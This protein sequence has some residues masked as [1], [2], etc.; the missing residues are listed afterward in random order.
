[1]KVDEIL[2]A[3]TTIE[4]N[5]K[6]MTF[7]QGFPEDTRLVMLAIDSMRSYTK[8]NDAEGFTRYVQAGLAASCGDMISELVN[9]LWE[10]L[11]LDDHTMWEE[12]EEKFL[13][14]D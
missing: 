7:C 13:S 9:T 10:E 14:A 11:G 1:M 4:Q 2:Y 12:F 8:D 6:R 5:I 3:L